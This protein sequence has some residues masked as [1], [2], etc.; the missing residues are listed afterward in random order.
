M[1]RGVIGS[2]RGWFAVW[3]ALTA[4]HQINKRLGKEPELV[5]RIV[6]KPGQTVE[7]RDTALRWGDLDR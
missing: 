4:A 3:V 7:I 2:S 1:Q 5:D 6:L